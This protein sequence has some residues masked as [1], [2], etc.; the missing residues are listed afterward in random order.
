MIQSPGQPCK[1]DHCR[2][3]GKPQNQEQDHVDGDG[4][5]PGETEQPTSSEYGG[6][7]AQKKQQDLKNHSWPEPGLIYSECGS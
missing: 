3:Q 1:K 7:I 5:R 4:S 2:D 6:C